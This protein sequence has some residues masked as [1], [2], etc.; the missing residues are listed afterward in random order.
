MFSVSYPSEKE[1]ASITR[2]LQN[3]EEFIDFSLVPPLPPPPVALPP[4]T[5]AETKQRLREERKAKKDPNRKDKKLKKLQ[6]K[7][8]K[9][10]KQHSKGGNREHHQVDFSE[11][12]STNQ[13]SKYLPNDEDF[14]DIRKFNEVSPNKLRGESLYA[15]ALAAVRGNGDSHRHRKSDD[16]EHEDSLRESEEEDEDEEDDED[17]SQGNSVSDLET[18][19]EELVSSVNKERNDDTALLPVTSNRIPS[20]NLLDDDADDVIVFQPAFSQFQHQ[21]PSPI[22]R[23]MASSKSSPVVPNQQPQIGQEQRISKAEKSLDGTDDVAIDLESLAYLQALHKKNT[24]QGWLNHHSSDDQTTQVGLQ[25]KSKVNPFQLE[26]VSSHE[27]W[28]PHKNSEMGLLNDYEYNGNAKHSFFM[29]PPQQV[30]DGLLASGYSWPNQ[31]SFS[32]YDRFSAPA[33]ADDVPPPPG[34]MELPAPNS[35]DY[36]L[37]SNAASF[38]PTSLRQSSTAPAPSSS[39]LSMFY[40]SDSEQRSWHHTPSGAYHHET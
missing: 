18:D 4:P 1:S 34:F 28:S 11:Y 21:Q 15:A 2:R 14:P 33:A 27:Y 22:S 13:D 25:N 8:E 7:K 40:G 31:S 3:I 39:R 10:Q 19:D 29:D 5:A 26:Q 12:P 17:Y 35:D 32:P 36:Q 16:S 30:S 9:N 23:P 20:A 38:L 6:K 37:N 24:E